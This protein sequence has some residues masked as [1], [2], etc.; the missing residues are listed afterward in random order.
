MQLSIVAIRG[1]LAVVAAAAVRRMDFDVGQQQYRK[2]PN[3]SL[4]RCFER[5]F[6]F[7]LLVR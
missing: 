4:I 3:I 1:Y 5:V 7:F 6:G 2:A